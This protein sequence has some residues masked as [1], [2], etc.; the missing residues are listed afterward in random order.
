VARAL[1]LAEMQEA[2]L[3]FCPT[4]DAWGFENGNEVEERWQDYHQ[5]SD[6]WP[7]A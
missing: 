5:N 1:P 3:E 7:Q 4:P 6:D 2:H